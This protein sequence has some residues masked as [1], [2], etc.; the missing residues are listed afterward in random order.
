MFGHKKML[1]DATKWVY[2][3]K[4]R[5]AYGKKYKREAG[6]IIRNIAH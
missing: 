6:E 4:I 5:H 2:E 1:C 3:R